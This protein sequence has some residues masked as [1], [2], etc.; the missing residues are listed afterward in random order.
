MAGSEKTKLMHAINSFFPSQLAEALGWTLLHSL[1]QGMMIAILATLTLIVLRRQPA[2]IRYRLVNVALL[3][4][5]LASVVTFAYYYRGG[6]AAPTLVDS[7]GAVINEE[8]NAAVAEVMVAPA[9]APPASIVEAST[10]HDYF[11]PHLPL[12]VLLWFVG[13]SIFLL[14]LLGNLAYI[15]YLKTHLVLPVETF[16]EEV[17]ENLM[18]QA[19]V[20]RSIQL[21]ESALVP[22]PVLA[23]YIKPVI[24]FPVGMINRLEVN[25]VEAILAHELSHILQHD[26]LLNLFQSLVEALFYFNPAVWW[27][28]AKIRQEREMAADDAA[29]ALTGDSVGFAKTLVL[30]QEMAFTRQAGQMAFGFAGNRK[31][32]LF[33]RV[34]HVLN[35][36]SPKNFNMEKIVGTLAVILA[37]IGLGYTQSATHGSFDSR[38]EESNYTGED[39]TGVWQ[40]EIKEDRLCMNL[41]HRQDHNSWSW[42]N[43]DCFPVSEF[44]TLPADGQEGEFLMDRPAGKMTF[45]GKFENKEGYGKFK[46]MPDEQFITWLGQQGITD[47]NENVMLMLFFA[48]TDRAY[49]T[50][51]KQA[52]YN[53]LNGDDL[54]GLAIHGVDIEKIKAYKE[55]ASRLGDQEPSLETILALSIHDVTPEYANELQGMGFKNMD[56]DDVMSFKIHEINPAYIKQVYAMGFPRLSPDDIMSFKIHEVTPEYLESLKKAGL[57]DLSADDVLS[58]KI[59]GVSP[60]TVEKFRAMGFNDLSQDDIV[61]LKIHEVDPEF[62]AD[63]RD[64]GFENLSV[65]EAMSLRIHDIDASFAADLKAAGFDKLSPDEIITC[66]IHEISAGFVS[67]LK[68]A[69]FDRLSF[70]DVISCK[71]HEVSPAQ[72]KGYNDL[73]FKNITVD[74]AI[75]LRIHEVSPEFI[76]K[77]RDKG[78]K[79]LILEDYI[80]LKIRFG[81]KLE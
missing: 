76:K 64:L 71:I 4:V 81:N 61:G 9:I 24:L 15:Q 74:D 2:L 22:S 42:S 5:L 23:G 27:L 50:A 78:F 34:Q 8:V 38:I 11:N 25:E 66:K 49:V 57:T 47:V 54:A 26:F 18:Q 44:S 59:Q 63:M 41:S 58:M 36:K 60:E 80:E 55:L 7:M 3:A 46:F 73:G 48:K 6:V 40:G 67:D 13:M 32:E 52:G 51:L 19:G 45:T 1:W 68:K 14:R 56:L 17:L 16:W 70:D 29:I 77:M 39:F 21:V 69:G 30:V 75:S 28:S 10:W 37:L 31:S 43:G 53:H 12:I 62:L 72:I 33:H 20:Q 79:D 35:I 65:D